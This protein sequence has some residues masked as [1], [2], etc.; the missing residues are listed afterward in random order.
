M[1]VLNVSYALTERWE[2]QDHLD[3]HGK[4]PHWIHF[5]DTVNGYLKS[6]YDKHHY[7]EIPH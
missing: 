7:K 6:D 2:S 1:I 4:T 3:A 5:N